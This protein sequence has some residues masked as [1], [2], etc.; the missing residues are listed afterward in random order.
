MLL[1]L[2]DLINAEELSNISH[3]KWHLDVPSIKATENFKR[4]NNQYNIMIEN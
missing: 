4:F 3:S 2:T 1:F